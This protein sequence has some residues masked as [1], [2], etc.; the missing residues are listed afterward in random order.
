MQMFFH[1]VIKNS[2]VWLIG[3]KGMLGQQIA[4][5]LAR[6]GI[7]FIGTDFEVDITDVDQLLSFASTKDF[8]WIVNCSAYTA[9]DKAESDET[10][11]ELINGKGVG[12]I[13]LVSTSIGAKVIHFSTDYV[14]DGESDVPYTPLDTPNPQSIYGKTKLSGELQLQ[15][16]CSKY[17][18]FRIAWLYGVYGNNFVKTM[19][20]LFSERD[21][22]GVVAD[23]FG[24]PTYC[25]VLAEN[26]INLILSG[27]EKYG[28]YHY[29]DDGM[30]SWY[31]FA[32][33]IKEIGSLNGYVGEV[34]INGITT[35]EYPTPAK[36]PRYSLLD[37][38]KVVEELGF[39]VIPWED[40][41][42]KYFVESEQQ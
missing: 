37:K 24:T 15:N 7:P 30:I 33:K 1:G 6:K 38:T 25:A 12:N 14:F 4:Q 35:D 21:S 9:V 31:D 22:L 11:A 5:E 32:V 8:E 40:N 13:A 42:A 27:S 16:N 17:F 41:L 39:K 23:Q 10:K 20:R 29:T 3:C 34:V 18:I 36:R 2:M 19:L 28:V 26:I